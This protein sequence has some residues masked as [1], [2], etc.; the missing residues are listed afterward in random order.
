MT[1]KKA[2]LTQKRAKS[3]TKQAKAAAKPNSKQMK[4]GG[5]HSS[6]AVNA[7]VKLDGIAGE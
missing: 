2:S 4:G 7:F 5:K 1:V 3:I 6:M